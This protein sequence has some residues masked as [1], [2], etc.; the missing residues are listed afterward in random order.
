MAVRV[1]FGQLRV[2]FMDDADDKEG[3]AEEQERDQ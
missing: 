1:F 2:E 3:E